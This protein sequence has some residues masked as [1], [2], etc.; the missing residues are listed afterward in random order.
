MADPHTLPELI[1]ALAAGSREIEAY[2]APL[3]DASF[4]AGDDA[5]WSPAHHLVHLTLGN[6]RFG[7]ALQ[8]RVALPAHETGRPMGLAAVRNLYEETLPK[9]ADQLRTNNP[10]PPKLDPMR[11]RSEILGE[12]LATNAALREAAAGWSEADADAKAVR[13]PIMGMFTV[14][15]MIAFFV[16]HDRHHLDGVRRRFAGPA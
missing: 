12:Y 15:D 2:F 9:V 3:P 5:H 16:I 14:R 1:D 10:N 4:F 8:A 13:H 7:R 11:T 6:V